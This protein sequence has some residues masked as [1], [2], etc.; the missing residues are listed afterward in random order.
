MQA[1]C[2]VADMLFY[3]LAILSI[4]CMI[5]GMIGTVHKNA[6]GRAGLREQ[7]VE[8]EAALGECEAAVTNC[9]YVMEEEQ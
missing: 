4:I 8:L 9:Y 1:R 6:Q 2:F 7:I 3:A 5:G